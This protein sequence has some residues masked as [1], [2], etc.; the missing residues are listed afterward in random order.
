MRLCCGSVKFVSVASKNA[1]MPYVNKPHALR[2]RVRTSG[3]WSNYPHP[4]PNA[5]ASFFFVERTK[6]SGR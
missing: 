4:K 3:K 6:A 1:E 2:V 5:H